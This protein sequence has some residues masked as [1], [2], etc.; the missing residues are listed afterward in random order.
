MKK[1]LINIV[2]ISRKQLYAWVI[3]GIIL[4][5]LL[6]AAIPYLLVAKNTQYVIKN[7]DARSQP[8]VKTGIVLGSLITKD[9][10]PY[11]QLESRLN[12]AAEAVKQGR[13]DQLILSGN[14]RPGYDEPAAMQRYLTQNKNIEPSKLYTDNAGHS[15]YETCERAAKV[16]N[17]RRAVLF[18]AES[19]LPRAIYLCR[20]FGIDTIGVAGKIQTSDNG[21]RELL[22][23]TKA[24]F[25]VYTYGEQ[26][27]LKPT[28]LESSFEK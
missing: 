24:V 13:V 21:S 4:I 7:E 10:R 16:F 28:S 8:H 22:A 6:L 1:P 18:S 5:F 3:I 27:D 11:Y 25:N 26:T 9:G 15:T 19:H 17:V 20:H 12:V 14:K 23:R 2:H